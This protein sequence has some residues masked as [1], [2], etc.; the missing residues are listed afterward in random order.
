[1]INCS[2]I[3]TALFNMENKNIVH[4]FLEQSVATFF[5]TVT[6]IALKYYRYIILVNFSNL[7]LKKFRVEYVTLVKYNKKTFLI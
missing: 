7:Y 3:V 2:E 5:T 6:L 1:M 4:I